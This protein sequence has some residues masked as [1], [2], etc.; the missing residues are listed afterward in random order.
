MLFASMALVLQD[1]AACQ[2]STHRI[3]P[4][5]H[6][7]HVA[8]SAEEMECLQQCRCV[9]HWALFTVVIVFSYLPDTYVDRLGRYAELH[10]H[11][12]HFE[13][14]KGCF[15]VVHGSF[16]EE[17]RAAMAL[18]LPSNNVLKVDIH[19]CK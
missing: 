10:Q 12:C 11:M 1:A 19:I 6:V 13:Q 9:Q 4:K 16:C 8:A 7:T 3:L 17:A 5:M 2:Q 18:V 15:A 14:S